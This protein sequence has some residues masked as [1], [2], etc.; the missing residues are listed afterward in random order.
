MVV[1]H[2]RGKCF[3]LSRFIVYFIIDTLKEKAPIWKKEVF[4]NGEEWV[5]ARPEL[6]A[7]A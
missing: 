3:T 2:C 4:E 1:F 6:T 5:S 7:K